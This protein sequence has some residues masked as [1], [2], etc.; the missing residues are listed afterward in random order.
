MF[1]ASRHLGFFVLSVVLTLSFSAFGAK[2]PPGVST[3]TSMPPFEVSSWLAVQHNHQ[4][5]IALHGNYANQHVMK[6]IAHSAQ[7]ARFKSNNNATSVKADLAYVSKIALL[8]IIAAMALKTFREFRHTNVE[9]EEN[10]HS[11]P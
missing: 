10:L 8:V 3:A 2:K 7:E 6:Y 4:D 11:T 9:E 5:Y 1:N